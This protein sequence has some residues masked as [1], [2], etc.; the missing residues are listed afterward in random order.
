M[1]DL[2]Q[3]VKALEARVKILEETLET[4]RNMSISGQMEN[5]IK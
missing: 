2:E 1:S 3:Q 4:L 5:C